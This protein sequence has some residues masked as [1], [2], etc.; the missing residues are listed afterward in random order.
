[1][2]R[3]FC[4]SLIVVSLIPI[5]RIEAQTY[6]NEWINYSQKYYS[7]KV[8]NTGIH[9]ID[10][11]ALNASGVPLSTILS[12]NLQLFG[13]EREIPL[14]VSD[15]GDSFMNP[16][17]Y[18]L[19]YATQNDGWLDSTLY[20]QPSDIGNPKYSL[21]NDTIE[22]FLTW[23]NSTNNLRYIVETDNAVSSYSPSNYVLF[24]K[25]QSNSNFYNEGEK[26]SEAS[27]SFYTSGEGWG[28]TPVNGA[29]GYVWDIGTLEMEQIYQGNDAPPVRYRAV[30]V[31][32]SNATYTGFGNHHV[33]H[34]IGSS[35][36]VMVDSIFTGYKAIHIDTSFASSVLPPNGSSNFK[37]SIINDQG[38]AT[39]YQSINYWSFTYPR[40]PNFGSLS[41]LNFKVI[42][43]PSQ[44]KIRVDLSAVTITNPLIFVHGETPRMLTF[45]PTGG[46]Q[47]LLLPNSISGV[48]QTVIIEP[49]ASTISVSEL[50]PVNST[51]NFND[52]SLFSPEKALLMVYHPAFQA[53]SADY[54]AYRI[55]NAGGMYNVILANVNELYRQFG[56][57]IPKHI[58]GIRRFAHFIYDQATE[59]P[60]GL[61]LMGKG[62]REANIGGISYTG[63]GSRTNATIYAESFIPSFGQPSCDACITSN[64]PGT[65]KWTPLM[66]SGR[67][68]ASTNQEL[69]EYLN[70]VQL[71]EQNQDQTSVY[72][73]L[74]KDWQKHVLHFVGGNA[75]QQELWG[76][77]MSVMAN[78]IEGPN[79]GGYVH[80][81]AQN[82]T[83]PINPSQLNAIMDRI[84]NGVSM[85]SFFGHA[86]PTATGFEINIDEPTNW[87]NTGKYPLVIANSCYN[88]NI[89]QTGESKSEKF[90]NIPNYG[91]IGYLGTVN[92]GFSNT[93]FTYSDEFYKQL[94][95]VNYGAT[96]GKQIQET[97]RS[98][99]NDG[100]TDLLTESTCSQM[101]LNGD[102]MVRLNWHEK[103]E[104]E[105]TEQSVSFSPDQLD[106]TVDSIE[107]SLILTNLGK[108]ILDTFSVEISRNFP[109]SSVDSVYTFYVPQ[110]HYKDTL[111]FNMPLQSNIGLGIN[112]FTVKVDLPTFVDEL[113]DEVNNNQLVKTLFIDVDGIVPVIPHEF[114]VVPE[115]S[116]TLVASTINPIAEYNTYK[117]ELDTTD[118]FNS[119]F[120]RFAIVSGLGGIKEVHPSQ[121]NLSSSGL[122]APLVCTDSMVYF[123]RVAIDE[124]NPAWKTS[125]FQYIVGKSGWGQDHFFQFRKNSFSALLYDDINRKKLFGPNNKTLTCDVKSTTATP[126]TFEN[127]FYID[128]DMKEYGLCTFT[129]SFYVAVIDPVSLTEWRTR[130]GSENPMN[131]FG[132]ANDNGACRPRTE[133]Y[134]IFRQNSLSQLNNFETMLSNVPDSHYILVY[135]PMT[136]YF[137]QVN[138]LLPSV[139]DLFQSLGSDS[140]VPGVV[141]P[142]LPFAFF[143]RKGDP[144]S[145]V[146]LYAQQA[147]ED[148]HLEGEL[149]GYDYTGQEFST[150]IGPAAE[151]GSVLWKQN[152]L[153]SVTADSTVLYIRAFDASGALQMV[154]DTA[155]TQNDSIVDLNA[156]VDAQNYPFLQLGAYYKDTVTFTPAQ[157]D[158]WHVLYSPLP[159]AAIDGSSG[160][161]WI[162]GQDTLSEGQ[163][164][165][166]A[167]DIKNIFNL[168]MDSL[169]VNYWIVDQNEVKHILS[170]PRQDSLT[171][172]ETFRDTISFSTV[173]LAGM[174]SF[175]MEVN[176]YIDANLTIT[177]QPEQ[178]HFNNL[179]QLPFY[180]SSDDKQPILDVTFNG[181]H[182]LN[183]D[184]VAPESE[185]YIT[186]KDDNEY[187]IMND[188]SD[189][190]HFGIYLTDPDGIQ[191][192]IPFIDGAGNTVMQWIPADNQQKKF[193][194]IYPANFTKDGKYTLLVQGSD[195]SGNLSGDLEYRI[196]FEVIHESMITYLMNYPN[197]FSTSTRFVFTL[198]GNEVPDE[199]LIQI[200]TVSGKVV[201]E[202]T[203]DQLGTIQIGRNI[204]EYAW[205]GKDEFGDPLANGVYLY[206]VK[207]QINGEDIKHLQSGADSHFK[208]E[209]GKMYIIR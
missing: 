57:G 184:I 145:V 99:E 129:P 208:K 55:S 152:S 39:D 101:T 121:W 36:F 165:Q 177:D 187:L 128:D 67:I 195:K 52:F 141:R 198:T 73:S 65:S 102:P 28:N 46:N 119:P 76:T 153:E 59:K 89:F 26:T 108:S 206:R 80:T 6:G 15:G 97:I 154:I 69:A 160:Y 132:N 183:N 33:K 196:T 75:S 197:P 4:L 82:T 123:W 8:Y 105:I 205:D 44:P 155:F 94:S 125:S 147:G 126:G 181:R 163:D 96:L 32:V 189:T 182:I 41:Q 170:Y 95:E 104:I 130:Y 107:I 1:M 100:F 134:F 161:T 168:P 207:A 13:K 118:L 146:E 2:L 143:C 148:L 120:K 190:T 136:T 71:H 204:S 63:P 87:N 122:S 114:A 194:I 61:F 127:A 43:N 139:Y 109:G 38:A 34:T 72:N 171:V 84:Q 149:I 64:L 16:G 23:N 77:F 5:S 42:N 31:G 79:F 37:I 21:Y 90:V 10:F 162:P 124:P 60:V 113:Y 9:K 98:I 176:P 169:L 19:F 175:W 200:M 62:I 11:D 116:V 159:E 115:D 88:G 56:G 106:L 7:F 81:T 68:A 117:F 179:L 167:V 180:V 22:Y 150:M 66:P 172:G 142:N 201:R 48:N 191:T 91:A 74:S 12:A 185:I 186:L 54:A 173:G 86:S 112:T 92:L 140:I 133:G 111:K 192:K 174:N 3:P 30:N 14:F 188:V 27:S 158:R 78:K 83:N 18:L 209:F 93:L 17:D 151:W 35:N 20:E 157:I 45:I 202:I 58:N 40:I 25:Y 24:E 51:G 135:S 70:K 103:P 49:A 166:F 131:N 47:S 156:L 85:I 203:E 110:L 199:I 164:A 193:K 138:S 29:S 137:D 178:A 53:A 144:N 50:F